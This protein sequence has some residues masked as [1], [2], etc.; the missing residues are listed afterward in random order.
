MQVSLDYRR[1]TTTNDDA[2]AGQIG[3]YLESVVLTGAA[4]ALTTGVSANITS[5]A[6]TAGD[7]D[8]NGV[9][10]FLMNAATVPVF[11]STSIN[12]VSATPATRPG[13]GIHSMYTV[14]LAGA[15][16][17]DLPTGVI[18]IS[19]AAPG[20]VYLVANASF[21]TNTAAAFG[22]LQARRAR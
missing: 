9:T 13:G 3:E 14:Q 8:V 17:F 22:K 20:T 6:L 4:V 18:R 15:T 10:C 1:G 21:T 5:L 16:I 2:S 11:V 19:L 12:T 7:W